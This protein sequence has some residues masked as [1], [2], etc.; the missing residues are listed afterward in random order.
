VSIDRLQP[1]VQFACSIVGGT[2]VAKAP[3]PDPLSATVHIGAR[4]HR[5]YL[6]ALDDRPLPEIQ[7]GTLVEI[8]LP[9]WALTNID[10]RAELTL[11]STLEMLSAGSIVFLGLSPRAVSEEDHKRFIHLETAV[12]AASY[13]LTDVLLMETLKIE[14]DGSQRTTLGP[15]RC[16]VSLLDIEAESLNH[17]LTLLSQRFEPARI[18]HSGSVF[19][20]G[21]TRLADGWVSLDDLRLAKVAEFLR[22]TSGTEEARLL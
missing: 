11:K 6:S 17:A 3:N 2:A 12:P 5:G 16:R 14:L 19:R 22:N 15:C 20:Q 7:D 21:F 9:A 13:L 18:S 10:E 4:W 8:V 1:S